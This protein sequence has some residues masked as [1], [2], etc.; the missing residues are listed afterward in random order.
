VVILRIGDG[1][2]AADRERITAW[3]DRW[4]WDY[5]DS[6]D[7]L[8]RPT[9][10][11]WINNWQ[12]HR[13]KLITI[14]AAATD[15]ERLFK[16]ARR[17]FRRQIAFNV[18]PDGETLD[19]YQR[20]ALHY[21]VYDLDPLLRAALV[22]R[23]YGGEDWYR[24]ETPGHASLARAVAWLTPY[25]SGR[26]THDEFVHSQVDFDAQRAAA[27]VKGFKGLFD[28][29]DAAETYWLAS[30]FDPALEP[31]ARSLGAEPDYLAL[32]GG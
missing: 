26:K 8:A 29:H 16:N 5:T 2:P 25:G 4:G 10:T 9:H 19:F 12:S 3:L 1:L 24:W 7:R 23:R 17:L 15:D 21:V 30:R 14:I 27:G 18:H 20:D 32:C 13:V 11:I 22:A 31:L 6:I 28:A